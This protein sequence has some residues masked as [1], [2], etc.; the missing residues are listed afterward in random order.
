M[1][2]NQTTSTKEKTMKTIKYAT[3][4][5]SREIIEENDGTYTAMSFT[6][7]KNFKTRKG[8]EKWLAKRG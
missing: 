2:S 1:E 3:K 7:S 5:I 6:A 4:T 8:A